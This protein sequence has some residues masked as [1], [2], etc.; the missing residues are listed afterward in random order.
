MKIAIDGLGKMGMQIAHRWAL[1]NNTVIAHNRSPEKIDY[2][3]EQF[4]AVPA[5]K[6][7]DVVSNFQGEQVILWIMIPAESV[8]DELREWIPILSPGDII[9]DGGNSDF[10]NT[11]KH[12]EITKAAGIELLDVGTSGGV[13]GMEHGFSMMVGGDEAAY[14]IIEPALE[15]LSTP[16]GGYQYFGPTG[17]G[18]FVKMVHNAIEYGIMESYAEGYRVL[19]EG[20]YA[21]LDLAAA[22]NVWQHGSII[23]SD[24]NGLN[25]QI[26]KENPELTGIVGYVAENGEATWTLEVAKEKSIEMPSISAALDVRLESQKGTVSYTTKLLAAMRNKFG[27]HDLNKNG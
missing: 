8:E 27:G 19:R 23:A 16:E 14:K 5:Y 7:E 4:G 10:R 15:P 9:V 11:K 6:K 22:A 25:V 20:P 12:Y 21:N 26:M 2:A 18:H 17:S 3:K 1:A 13:L 24:L